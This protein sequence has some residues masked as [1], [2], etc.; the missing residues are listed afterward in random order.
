RR[1]PLKLVARVVEPG[2]QQRDD[3]HPEAHRGQP[4]DRIEDRREPASELAV[5]AIVEALEIDLVEIDP[6][7]Q[8]F[9]YLRRPVA[10]RHVAGREAG[11][12]RFLEYGDGPFARDERLVVR[13]DDHASALANRIANEMAGRRLERR[14]NRLW[15]AQRLRRHPVLTVRAVQIAAEHPEAV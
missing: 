5:M 8:V 3:L 4:A 2:N 13:A 12:L 10:V 6:R 15:I 9:E 11:R 7:P 14:R 1:Q